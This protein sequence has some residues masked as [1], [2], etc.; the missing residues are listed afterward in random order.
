MTADPYRAE[1]AAAF[2]ERRCACGAPACSV[3]IGFAPVIE[4]GI[5]LKRE[6]PDRV[7]CLRCL[8]VQPQ[9]QKAG[10]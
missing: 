5:L 1:L 6:V 7:R 8:A 3:V 9:A 10:E 4:A 2:A